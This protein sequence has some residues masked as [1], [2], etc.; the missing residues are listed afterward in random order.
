MAGMISYK[1]LKGSHWIYFV[2]YLGFIVAAEAIGQYMRQRSM[3]VANLRLYNYLVI[4]IEFLFNFL[5]FWFAFGEGKRKLPVVFT[6]IYLVSWLTDVLLLSRHRFFFYSFSYTIGNLLL[7]ILI[8]RFFLNLVTSNDILTFRENMQF[9]VSLGLLI[10]ALTYDT[11]QV[12]NRMN[13]I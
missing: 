11:H 10:F 8:L 3:V 4:P 2:W 7:L 12:L 6:V 9:W 1:R 5:L 13:Q